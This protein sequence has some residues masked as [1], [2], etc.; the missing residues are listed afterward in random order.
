MKPI[1]T[2]VAEA[3][4]AN[5]ALLVGAL[6]SDPD[7][8]VVGEARSGLEAVEM[9]KKLL[10]DIVT[11]DVRMPQLDGFEATRQI[12]VESPTPIVVVSSSVDVRDV[13]ASMHALRAGALTVVPMPEGPE[14]PA[15]EE[16]TRRFVETVKSLSQ[17]KVVR[18]WPRRETGSEAPA[19]T[20]AN[21]RPR[22]VAIGASTGGPAA[23][24]RILSELPGDFPVPILVVQHI[25]RGFIEGV[26]AWMNTAGA[27]RVKVAQDG[28]PLEARK[29]YL[30]PDGRHLGVAPDRRTIR[31]SDEAPIGGFRPSATHL[32]ESVAKTFGS[33][34][35]AVIL[36]G[37]GRDGV[38]GLRKVREEGG[39]IIGQ[40]EKTAV[41]YGMPGAA[42]DA[43]LVDLRLPIDEIAF[44][45][46]EKVARGGPRS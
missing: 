12:M 32:F 31:I 21:A 25:S 39:H 27:L 3:S 5:R 22:V 2:L 37:M 1:R 20:V 35:V 16:T 18:R 45:I 46:V 13:E 8:E 15:F 10:P 42:A 7:I 36:T 17:V 34:A 40:D 38:D 19:P 44:R 11:M 24:S 14:S 6:R 43:G 26:A 29:V 4:S 33:A 9:T 28:E 23:I 30:A 41:V